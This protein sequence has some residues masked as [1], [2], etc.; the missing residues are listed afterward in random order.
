MSFDA[1]DLGNI[2]TGLVGIAI[3]GGLAQ[4]TIKTVG[5]LTQ[6]QQQTKK[7]KKSQKQQN[8]FDIGNMYDYNAPKKK[9]K[10]SQSNN[11]FSTGFGF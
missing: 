2:A 8:I 9:S 10:K 6:P 7:K 4:Q 11:I 1:G 5:N 3:V